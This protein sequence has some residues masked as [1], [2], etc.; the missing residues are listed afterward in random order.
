MKMESFNYWASIFNS[1]YFTEIEW[2]EIE[3]F[4]KLEKL[5]VQMLH[6]IL[7]KS[8]EVFLILKN[9]FKKF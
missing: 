1:E 9:W 3:I 2:N 8:L 6:L 4:I 7:L 5:F